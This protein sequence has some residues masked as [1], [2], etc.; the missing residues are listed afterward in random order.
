MA[1]LKLICPRCK[2]EVV[3]WPLRRSDNCSPKHWVTCIRN[4]MTVISDAEKR[5]INVVIE[6]EENG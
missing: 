6:E 3:G 2:R 1:K 4:L 5:G